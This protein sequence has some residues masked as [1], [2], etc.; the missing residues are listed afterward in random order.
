MRAG[1]NPKAVAPLLALTAASR[2]TLLLCFCAAPSLAQSGKEPQRGFHPAGSYSLGDVETVSTTSGNM[3]LRVP[4]A[5]LPAGRGGSP[6]PGVAL[7]YN[8]K[9]WDPSPVV[10]PAARGCS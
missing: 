8:S 10:T 4:L 2:L 6:G 9:L 1:H 3:M 5:S 7:I